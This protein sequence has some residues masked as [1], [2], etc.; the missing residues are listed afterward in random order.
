MLRL[1]VQVWDGA[2]RDPE[3][4]SAMDLLNPAAMVTTSSHRTRCGFTL[5]CSPC[6]AHPALL[7]QHCLGCA[8][9]RCN[10]QLHRAHGCRACRDEEG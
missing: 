2:E 3:Y 6:T 5:H 8:G 10:C 9:P 4:R 1:V 7:T